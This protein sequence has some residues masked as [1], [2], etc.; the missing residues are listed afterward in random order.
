MAQILS[1]YR[2]IAPFMRSLLIDGQGNFRT[3]LRTQLANVF[4]DLE[5]CTSDK[6]IANTLKK[7]SY[8]VV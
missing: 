8:N 1:S 7:E 4:M 2:E 5:T 3:V 6:D